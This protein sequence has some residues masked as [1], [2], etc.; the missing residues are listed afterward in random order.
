MAR[1]EGYNTLQKRHK[2]DNGNYVLDS[3]WTSSDTVEISTDGDSLT[4]KI[5]NGVFMSPDMSLDPSGITIA[6]INDDV[7]STDSAWS[8]YKVNELVSAK[9]EINDD[10][11]SGNTTYSSQKINEAIASAPIIDDSTVSANTTFSSQ[12]ISAYRNYNTREIAD[13]RNSI[14]NRGIVRLT[15]A[16]YDAS[17]AGT[18]NCILV[19]GF[20]GMFAVLRN[21][22]IISGFT[23]S[24]DQN[25][26]YIS[27]LK[28]DNIDVTVR[29]TQASRVLQITN[30]SQYHRVVF[31]LATT[32]DYVIERVHVIP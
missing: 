28:Q 32:D 12:N 25:T 8:S 26:N 10:A 5:N 7:V 15:V 16:G 4:N 1:T 18:K 23:D 11:A 14:D 17:D 29:Y 3:L 27:Y 9:A 6:H 21:G 30:A 19:R 31:L 13:L 22:N 24:I 20:D 2:D